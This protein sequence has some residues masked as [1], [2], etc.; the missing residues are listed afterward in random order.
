[1]KKTIGLILITTLISVWFVFSASIKKLNSNINTTNINE[2]EL[3]N[4]R[5]SCKD[6]WRYIEKAQYV[7]SEVDP[8]FFNS[9]YSTVKDEADTILDSSSMMIYN[10][11]TFNNNWTYKTLSNITLNWSESTITTDTLKIINNNVWR[12]KIAWM[13]SFKWDYSSVLLWSNNWSKFLWFRIY[14]NQTTPI[15]VEKSYSFVW[16]NETLYSCAWYYV[17]KCGDWIRDDI[18]KNWRDNTDW[19]YWILIDWKIMYRSNLNPQEECDDWNTINWDWCSSTC[20]IETSEPPTCTVSATQVSNW[21]YDV[22]R[23]IDWTFT[24]WNISINNWWIVK[25][26]S[27]WQNV[28]T[29]N[30]NLS[31]NPTNTH[32]FFMTVKNDAWSNTCEYSITEQ[33]SAPTC[34]LSAEEQSDWTRDIDRD[35]QWEDRSNTQIT[36]N[37]TSVNQS[38]Y[39][40]TVP[41]W[42]RPNIRT[43]TFGDY[44]AS[45]TVKNNFGQNTCTTTFDAPKTKICG[46]WAIESPNDNGIREECDDWNTRNWDW[47]DRSCDLETPNCTLNIDWLQLFGNPTTFSATKNSRARYIKFDIDYNNNILYNNNIVFPHKFTYP[48]IVSTY[49]PVLTVENNI[50]DTNIRNWIS[51][52]TATCTIPVETITWC[53]ITVEPKENTIWSLSRIYRNI[54]PSVADFSNKIELEVDPYNQIVWQRPKTINRTQWYTTIW[55]DWNVSIWNYTFYIDDISRNWKRYYCSDWLRLYEE[56]KEWYLDVQKSLITTWKLM[57]WDFVDFEITLTNT[58]N[59]LY[60]NVSVVDIMPLTLDFVSSNIIWTP[61]YNRYTWYTDDWN[62]KI[63]YS[64]FNLEPWE[65]ITVNIR[66]QVKTWASV[67]Y[68]TNCVYTDQDF[69]CATYYLSPEPKITKRQ[70]NSS[71][72]TNFT[73]WEIIVNTW[74]YISYRIDFENIWW[75]T[76]TWWIEIIDT[77][78]SCVRYISSDIYW[79]SQNQASTVE[80]NTYQDINGKRIIE[81]D[82]FDLNY[83]ENGY[84]VITW[85]IMTWWICGTDTI[86][87]YRNIAYLNFQNP[88]MSTNAETTAYKWT[89]SIIKL[90]KSSNTDT[91]LPWDTK[92]FMIQIEN[93]GPNNISDIVLQDIWPSINTCISYVSRTGSS[94][95]V[96]DP[97]WL[98]WRASSLNTGWTI[99][100]NISWSISNNES[101]VYSGYEN[102]ARL[103]YSEWGK[104]YQQEDLYHFAISS[105]P[106]ADISLIKTADKNIVTSWDTI[107]Y[108]I[109]YE[110]IGNTTLNNYTI[111]DYWPGMIDFVSANPFPSNVNNTDTWSILTWNFY[112]SLT[113][114]GTWEIKI[115]W[116]VK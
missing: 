27:L 12:E 42:T 110:N 38:T 10:P 30:Y 51:R 21:T 53:T 9:Y 66:W 78:P 32:T 34:T 31:A 102:I 16:Y 47:C 25:Y 4:I 112:N 22:S 100:L 95:L 86:S 75:D 56:T 85:Q 40:I 6:A 11:W 94:N 24:H 5:K 69:D 107:T 72:N 89:K 113:P 61:N 33:W 62:Y 101:C 109:Y 71:E 92:L 74:D 58:W 70:K 111:V 43:D 59:W 73:T 98:I 77:M 104:Q 46:N 54:D 2:S 103:Q 68:T 108:T 67:N 35:I 87:L 80:T 115:Q 64:W 60:E 96:K 76:T 105:T 48:S 84:I 3:Q 79:L 41:S 13:I 8:E 14:S 23:S 114:W 91:S 15:Y 18:N 19:K 28:W 97:S 50:S 55:A 49:N 65:S 83:W 99:Y 29:E 1:M 63:T 7:W 116:K 45:M 93:E 17:A 39:N 82:W 57:P 36:I 106:V 20:Q 81:Y 44:T 52:P 26:I 37:P 88:L 90:T